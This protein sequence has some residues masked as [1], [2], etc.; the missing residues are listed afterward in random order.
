[1]KILF[2]CRHNVFR[3]KTAEAYFKKICKDK[4]IKA[5]SSGIFPGK[6]LEK[7]QVKNAR[8]LGIDLKGTPRGTSIAL[9]KKQDLVIV[10]ADDIPKEIFEYSWL[11]GKVKILRIPDVRR[12][13]DTEGNIKTIKIIMKKVNEILK[14]LENKK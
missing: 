4:N 5:E 11:K 10:V 9:L 6:K 13:D 14:G 12:G 3:S 2:M 1:M 8:E 7:F